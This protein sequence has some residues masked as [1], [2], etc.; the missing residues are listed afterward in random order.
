MNSS[1]VNLPPEILWEIVSH[2]SKQEDTRT[3]SSLFRTRESGLT[4]SHDHSEAPSGPATKVCNSSLLGPS[5][6][7]MRFSTCKR[8]ADICAPALFHTIA[9]CKSHEKIVNLIDYLMNIGCF[10]KHLKLHLQ[11]MDGRILAE[12]V[13][14][15]SD[16]QC[17]T[18]YHCSG[19]ILDSAQLLVALKALPALAEL[20]SYGASGNW[21][22]D[23]KSE[24]VMLKPLLKSHGDRLRSLKISGYEM[25]EK[26]GF[27][28]LIHDAPRLVELDIHHSLNVGL[29]RSLA[30]S[31]TWACASHLQSLTFIWCGGL[32]AGIFTQKLASGAF[33]HP[34]KVSL[35]M[36]GTPADD[37]EP[38]EVIEWSIP[39]LDILELDY[40]L[41]W[42]MEHLL[43]IHAKKVF[44]SH[45]WSQ[46]L[47]GMYRV[48]IQQIAHKRAFPEAAEIHVTTDWSNEDFGEL[49]RVCPARGVKL[50]RGDRK[51]KY[52]VALADIS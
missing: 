52:G 47:D 43:L 13:D 27:A 5:A 38:P 28:S 45:V 16:L 35:A 48:V 20:N 36:C 46:S 49:R 22:G 40:F 2:I 29:R 44:L 12:I 8:L 3:P 18:I 51:K 25:L 14:R 4:M 41:T 33:G 30:E 6:S 32:H 15:C 31:S 26:G 23:K 34:R 21:W 37:R 17:L 10:V 50:I 19:E 24:D 39:A 1:L 42:E 11:G 7:L 9:T